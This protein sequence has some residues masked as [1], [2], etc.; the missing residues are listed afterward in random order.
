MN[1]SKTPKRIKS[2]KDR[3]DP[4]KETLVDIVSTEKLP[5]KTR[6]EQANEPLYLTR[7]E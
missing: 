2:E 3:N 7:Y 1:E 4:V 6:I 5:I